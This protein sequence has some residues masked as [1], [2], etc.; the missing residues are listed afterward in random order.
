MA[1]S[2]VSPVYT[3]YVVSGGAKYNL[4]P[5]FISVDMS[6]KEQ[7]MAQ[8]VTVQLMNV[9]VGGKP[10]SDLIQVRDRVY[11]HANDGEKN[12]EVFRGFVWTKTHKATL[13]ERS[14]QIKCYDNLIYFQES[15]ESAFFASGKS[16][17][18]VCG[19]LCSNWGVKL[20]YS[21]DSIT[22]AK[23]VL[24]GKLADIFTSDILD[25]V[26]DRTSKKYVM[27]SIKD[28]VHIR[29]VGTNSTI[30]K[31][32]GQTNVIR[33][34]S[35]CTMDG[36]TTKVII[37]GKADDDE[38]EPIEA[39]VTGNTGTYGTLQKII[40]RDENTSLADAKKEAQSIIDK[41][42]TPKWE[43]ELKTIDIPW[44]RLGDKVYVDAGG[45]K[46]YLIVIG[47]DRSIDNKHKEMTLTLE[48]P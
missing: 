16:T 46:G 47:V 4:S 2:K 40:D 17:K 23:L 48:K 28:T 35:E 8:S 20:Q 34:V 13:T 30:Y 44:I 7:Q 38:R 3:V 5:A 45:F 1:A 12:E 39:T 22:H 24:R 14:F 11:L 42:G 6:E 37:V 36:M 33:L 10:L 41:D 29:S 26:K 21:Y 15:E 43:Y 9:Q 31:F 18:D 25:L 27:L 32:I 19:T